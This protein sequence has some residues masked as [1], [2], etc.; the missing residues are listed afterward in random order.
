MN[1]KISAYAKTIEALFGTVL[2]VGTTAL[3]WA[4]NDI[5]LAWLG[6]IQV[7]L[8]AMTVFR[9]WLVKNEPLIEQ[10]AA[11]VES[12]VRDVEHKDVPAAIGTAVQVV[13]DG[14]LGA[15]RA[16]VDALLAEIRGKHAAEQPPTA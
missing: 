6:G 15:D 12:V 2:M 11:E 9:V 4:S 3:A 10:A 5:P 14:Q 8:A 1:T 7:V 13:T 16:A